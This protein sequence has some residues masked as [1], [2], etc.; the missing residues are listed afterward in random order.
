[1]QKLHFYFFCFYNSLYKDGFYLE[2]YLKTTGRGKILPERRTILGL[3]FSTW[4]WTFVVR[5]IIIDLFNP[6]LKILF[7][8]PLYEII[9]AAIIYAAYFFYFVGNNRFAGF[10][11]QYK[12]TDK[13][14][15]R[16]GVRRV[17]CF[18]GLPLLLIPLLA[19]L[20]L[21]CLHIDLTNH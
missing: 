2:A 13:I 8:D 9:M 7:W 18:L 14:I 17:Y 19:W 12:S 21:D 1:M 11:A 5:L 6:N 16:Q 20:T 3:S 10:Y 4:L 15:Q